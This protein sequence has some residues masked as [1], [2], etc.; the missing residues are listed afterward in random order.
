MRQFSVPGFEFY[1]GFIPGGD[2]PFQD[3]P[4]FKHLPFFS[5]LKKNLGIVFNVLKPYL[6]LDFFL[7]VLWLNSSTA[8]SESPVDNFISFA[9]CHVIVLLMREIVNWKQWDNVKTMKPT[10]YLFNV[11][12]TWYCCFC[13]NINL[14]VTHSVHFIPTSKSLK[15][16]QFVVFSHCESPGKIHW[17]LI[18]KWRVL[19]ENMIHL[20]WHSSIDIRN[21]C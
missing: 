21:D 19:L 9:F 5:F 15:H 11:L 14:R 7:K 17:G 8:L 13:C 18:N 10:A 20:F 16:F 6:C 12:V 3:I 4:C 2:I 1:L